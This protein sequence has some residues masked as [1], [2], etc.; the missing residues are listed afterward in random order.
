MH[1]EDLNI[2]Q[3][4]VNDFFDEIDTDALVDSLKLSFREQS[5]TV[6]Q[7]K[8]TYSLKEH[9]DY[10][11]EGVTNLFSNMKEVA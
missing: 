10:Y 11:V 3:E 5:V 9:S 7:G 6:S 4:S 1:I 2:T 8:A